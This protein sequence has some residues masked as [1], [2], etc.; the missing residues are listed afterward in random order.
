MKKLAL[1][2]L[3]TL[4][5]ACKKENTEEKH[6]KTRS[7]RFSVSGFNIQVDGLAAKMSSDE[8][9]KAAASKVLSSQI[10]QLAFI[11]YD[12]NG[13]EFK[14]SIQYSDNPEFGTYVENLPVDSW[15]ELVVVGSKQTFNLNSYEHPDHSNP[16]LSHM[17]QARMMYHQPILQEVDEKQYKTDDTFY[18]KIGFSTFNESKDQ[19]NITMDRVVGKLEINVED[20]DDYTVQILNEA[21]EFT[22]SDEKSE[23]SIDD[24]FGHEPV[25][26]NGKTLCFYILKTD[27]PLR[28][29]IYGEGVEKELKVPVFKNKR[30]TVSGKLLTPETSSTLSVAI[31]EEWGEDAPPVKF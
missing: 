10:N 9:K 25:K 8:E 1:L 19:E 20:T 30:T 14:R 2:L 29:L 24:D 3:A 5:L 27:S 13:N 4:A 21:T 18:R 22:F 15:F 16:V 11:I 26:Y 17:T 6:G 28:I 23:N 31:N 7:M 12:E